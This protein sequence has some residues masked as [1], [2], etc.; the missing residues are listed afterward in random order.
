MLWK[1]S[2][3]NTYIVFILLCSQTEA[4]SETFPKITTVGQSS[5]KL[6]SVTSR[7]EVQVMRL[8]FLCALLEKSEAIMLEHL[9]AALAL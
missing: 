1:F 2:V 6:G 9:V 8:A 5:K 3:N 7:A 4:S